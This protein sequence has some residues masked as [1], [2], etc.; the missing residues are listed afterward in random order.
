VI[1]DVTSPCIDAGDPNGS[2][3]DELFP[4][5]G[6]INIGA[7]GGTT[8]ASKSYFGAPACQRHSAG[9]INGDCKVDLADLLIVISQWTAE[10]PPEIPTGPLSDVVIVEPTG[11]VTLEIRSNPVLIRAEAV[12]PEGT[13]IAVTFEI[14]HTEQGFSYTGA[15]PGRTGEHGWY[16]EW[17]WTGPEYSLPEGEY[18][19]V[20]KATD[21]EGATTTSAPVTITIVEAPYQPRR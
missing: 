2:L 7:Y 5:G 16:L 19:I 18:T 11:G 8:E 3:G 1:D 21:S 6:R 15:Y 20:A 9:D 17:D 4:N 14:S 12:D 10:L 13:I